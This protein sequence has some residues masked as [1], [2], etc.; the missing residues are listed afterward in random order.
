M[1]SKLKIDAEF[2]RRQEHWTAEIARLAAEEGELRQG[3]GA[4]AQARQREQGK[5][6]ARER[7]AALCDPGAAFLELG[8]WAAHG[9]YA[10]WAERRRRGW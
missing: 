6:A 4:K 9:M 1:E 5:L 10:E 3:G 2:R 8:L 7:V